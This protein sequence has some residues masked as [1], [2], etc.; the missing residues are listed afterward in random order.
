MPS[1]KEYKNKLASLSNTRKITKTM[2]M[3]AASKLYR[4]MDAQRRAYQFYAKL[5]ELLGRLA[6]SVDHRAHPLL[7]ARA[8][9]KSALVMV[10][11]C[12]TRACAAAST[13]T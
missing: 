4:T 11:T 6:A 1:L 5:E 3:V 7:Q 2:K 8:H 10:S 13:T 9:P 12:P